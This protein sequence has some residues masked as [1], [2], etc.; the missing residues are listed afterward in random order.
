MVTQR[1]GQLVA[2]RHPAFLVDLLEVAFDRSQRQMD[3]SHKRT[4]AT[5]DRLLHYAHVC[6]TTG[7][8]VRFQQATSGKGVTP[9]T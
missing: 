9:L 7:D 6:V 8:S 4:G 3:V 5:V 2:S 1:V